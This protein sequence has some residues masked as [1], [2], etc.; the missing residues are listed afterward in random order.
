MYKAFVRPHLDYCDILY[1]E[2]AKVNTFG[3]LLTASMEDVERIQYRAALVVTGAWKGS[4]RSNLYDELGWESLSDRRYS[5]RILQLH[6][7]ENN[8]TPRLLK[9]KLPTHSSPII[10]QS[11]QRYNST[12]RYK[13]S[14]FPDA[15]KN[16]N[17]MIP[18]FNT[19]PKFLDLK[20]NLIALF[21]PKRKRTFDIY[22]PIGLSYIF[23][24]RVGL[25]PLRSHKNGIIS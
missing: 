18:H 21:R 16:W 3:Q 23:Q 8:Q 22:D 15:I 25:S 12:D 4:N 5:R 19:V 17:I 9:E 11:L 20:A 1:H 6:K 7:I 13:K 14:F 10:F 24:L 2:P